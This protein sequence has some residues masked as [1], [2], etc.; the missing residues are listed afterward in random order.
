MSSVSRWAYANTATVRPV[1]GFD[2]W[3]GATTYGPEY[4]IACTWT[5]A[6]EQVRESGGQSGAGGAELIAK[7]FIFT[8]DRRPKYLDLIQFDGS[9]GWEQ[10]RSITGWDMS[11][12]GEP[13]SPDFRLAT[14]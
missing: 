7:H 12:L 3:T 2:D 9:D 5:A 14:A 10:I 13:D 1:A 8:E 6:N 4:Q 11:A